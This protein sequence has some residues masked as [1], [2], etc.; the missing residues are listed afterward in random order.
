MTVV[1][2]AAVGAVALLLAASL[3]YVLRPLLRRAQ[4]ARVSHD[5]AN[6]A[7]Y[8]DQ[9]R[10]LEADLSA[11]SITPA[12]YESA[13]LEIEQRLL[14]DVKGRERA[15]RS[16]HRTGTAALAF[17]VAIPVCALAVYWAVGTPQAWQ[18]QAMQQADPHALTAERLTLM[19][20]KLAARLKANPE[21]ADGWAMLARSYG[22]LGRYGE[23]SAA[24]A[25][26]A[27]RSPK[28]AQLLADHAD[29]LGMAQG[30][31]LQGEPEKLIERALQI[32]P[33]NVK[34]LALAG[35]IAFERDQFPV[36][37]KHW[38]RVLQLIP[39][40]APFAKSV[41]GSI[42]EARTLAG[43]SARADPKR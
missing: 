36:A 6:V 30:R 5:A 26:A 8:R 29:V 9:L 11:G 13:R 23:A 3:W 28:D 40:D 39:A 1:P 14:E 15:A 12:A 34:A 24:Y 22:T 10:E 42:D 19:I 35:T 4:G 25:E 43:K 38:E 7:V 20:D 41:Q 16:P 27:R 33:D 37:V 31:R 17:G 32:D 18:A 21:D 2:A